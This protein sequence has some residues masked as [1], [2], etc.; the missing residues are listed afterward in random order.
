MFECNEIKTICWWY[1]KNCVNARDERSQYVYL[2]YNQWVWSTCSVITYKE[3]AELE[4][5]DCVWTTESFLH[6]KWSDGF[7]KLVCKSNRFSEHAPIAKQ[8]YI[9][10]IELNSCFLNDDFNEI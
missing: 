1:I 6:Q 5:F 8:V 10:I 9:H 7:R 2:K 4:I 3:S